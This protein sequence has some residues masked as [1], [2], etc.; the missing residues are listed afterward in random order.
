MS[1]HRISIIIIP[2]DFLA[3]QDAVSGGPV[4]AT[5][6]PASPCGPPFGFSPSGHSYYGHE[7]ISRKI[8]K[9]KHD[10]SVYTKPPPLVGSARQ[11]TLREGAT[12][13][14]TT[15]PEQLASLLIH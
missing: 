7:R 11:E 10:H 4:M 13:P 2:N 9:F 3:T 5:T 8:K 12:R 14:R 15:Q 6:A 1:P